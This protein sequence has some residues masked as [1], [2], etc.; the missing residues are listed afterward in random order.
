M[1]RSMDHL[2]EKS[3]N[4]AMF[5]VAVDVKW[6]KLLE[7]RVFFKTVPQKNDSTNVSAITNPI[8][9]VS[10]GVGMASEAFPFDNKGQT[11]QKGTL[12]SN[13]AASNYT[14][15]WKPRFLRLCA[16]LRSPVFSAMIGVILKNLKLSTEMLSS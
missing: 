1:Y 13:C 16:A 12:L 5:L 11:P 15:S 8:L 14:A 2:I 3:R 9:C 4:I 7:H 6:L 10:F